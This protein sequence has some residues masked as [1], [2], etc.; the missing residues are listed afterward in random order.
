MLEEAKNKLKRVNEE[1]ILGCFWDV[2][3]RRKI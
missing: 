3:S 2:A 1:S